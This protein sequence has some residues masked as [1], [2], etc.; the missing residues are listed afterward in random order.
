MP[1]LVERWRGPGP[2][3]SLLQA[4]P[5]DVGFC[6]DE[7]AI[8]NFEPGPNRPTSGGQADLL[9]ERPAAELVRRICLNEIRWMTPDQFTSGMASL[10]DEALKALEKTAKQRAEGGSTKYV[11]QAEREVLARLVAGQIALMIEVMTAS[12]Y[13]EGIERM[14]DT[15]NGRKP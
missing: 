9:S 2:A 13:G 5:A 3:R 12:G 11:A 1:L 15:F 6:N 8:K 4:I 10:H 14:E 7:T